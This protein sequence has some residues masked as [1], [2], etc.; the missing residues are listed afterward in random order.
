MEQQKI[1]VDFEGKKYPVAVEI[2]YEGI[3][4]HIKTIIEGKQMTF[5]PTTYDGLQIRPENHG[6][7]KE[8]VL[9]VAWVVLKGMEF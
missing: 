7:N 5:I 1:I 6:L 8:L 3:D 2:T 9:Q 4:C